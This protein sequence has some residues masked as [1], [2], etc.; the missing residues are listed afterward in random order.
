M[1]TY[2]PSSHQKIGA[3]DK[4]ALGAP[5]RAALEYGNSDPTSARWKSGANTPHTETKTNW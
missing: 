5:R 3:R 4:I 2:N 1:G